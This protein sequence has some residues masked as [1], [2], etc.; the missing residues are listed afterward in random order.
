MAGFSGVS[1]IVFESR[2]DFY[3]VCD[4]SDRAIGGYVLKFIDNSYVLLEN[5]ALTLPL[6]EEEK[7][8]SSTHR[9]LLVFFKFLAFLQWRQFSAFS[10]K[11]VQ[12]VSDNLGLI[13]QLFKFKTNLEFT[14]I[15]VQKIMV[16]LQSLGVKSWTPFW[17]RR[18]CRKLIIADQLGRVKLKSLYFCKEFLSNFQHFQSIER[19]ILPLFWTICLGVCL[20]QMNKLGFFQINLLFGIYCIMTYL[21]DSVEKFWILLRCFRVC[22]LL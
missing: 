6:T 17:E 11:Y 16:V 4:T 10:N 7:L 3:C 20:S 2:P 13:V 15:L 8:L 18:N 19:K 22:I 14:D 9:E 1:S 12:I 21:F 5:C